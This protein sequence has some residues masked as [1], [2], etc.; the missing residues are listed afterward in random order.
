MVCSNDVAAC[1]WYTF[2]KVSCGKE[3]IGSGEK[4]QLFWNLKVFADQHVSTDY[5]IMYL[6]FFCTNAM[7]HTSRC[8]LVPPR[9]SAN[10]D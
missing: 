7:W 10:L 4:L 2:E 6:F 1:F 3:G 8:L 9:K 5:E